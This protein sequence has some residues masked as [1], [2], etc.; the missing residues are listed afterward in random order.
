MNFNLKRCGIGGS[1]ARRRQE[2][3]DSGVRRDNESDGKIYST[4]GRDVAVMPPW[5]KPHD[6]VFVRTKVLGVS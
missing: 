1:P 3:K 6:T 2:T 5:E 4:I